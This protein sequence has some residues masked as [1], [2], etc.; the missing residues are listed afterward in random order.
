MTS[1]S[2][3]FAWLGGELA[4]AD[5]LVRV[6]GDRIVRVEPGGQDPAAT[7]LAGLTVPGFAD[8]HV[9]AFHRALRSRAEQPG[10]FWSWR[11]LMYS[12][13]E[14][15]DPDRLY[16]L[17][18]AAYVEL[19][20]AGVTTVGE[21][22]YLHHPPGGARYDN[23]NEMSQALA[24]AA[25]DAGM[26]L[27]LLD[28]CYLTAGADGAELSGVQLRFGDGDVDGW[29]ARAGEMAAGPLLRNGAAIHSVR[30]VPAGALGEVA[31]FARRRGWPLHLHLSE[32]PAENDECLAVHGLSPAALCARERV[33]GDT[34][35]AVH[36]IHLDDG[37]VQLLA[38]SGTAACLCPT[39]ERSLADG[40]AP[41][42]RLA[43]AGVAL[44]LGSDSLAVG[45]PLEEMR[46]VELDERL[47]S[48]RRGQLGAPEL[49]RAATT[50][51]MRC[52][53]WPS[54][55]IAAGQPAD[56]VTVALDTVRTAG[57][58]DPLAAAVFAATAADVRQVMCAG[59]VVVQDGRHAAAPDPGELVGRAVRAVFE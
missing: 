9:H 6:E 52:L 8:A 51:G 20:L 24:R 21:F 3:E 15:L 27:T 32:Q 46:A 4:V 55:G 39:T 53:G 50:G 47:V 18:F 36:A 33:L 13:A 30:A 44:A 12:V 2:C 17:A 57:A 58:A 10:D 41:A 38:E 25:A 16:R 48:G 54:G 26:R 22:H 45:D 31:E 23:P 29:A 1:F 42:V 56:L 40:V 34:T 19:A 5:V 49:L 11:R 7:R 35:T 37:D 14:R 59:R 43:G 28:T